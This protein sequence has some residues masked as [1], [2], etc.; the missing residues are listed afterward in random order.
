ML[1]TLNEECLHNEIMTQTETRPIVIEFH[2]S[3][4]G[5]SR[6]LTS[7]IEQLSN[8]LTDRVLFYEADIDKGK[9]L[10]EKFEICSVPTLILI[11]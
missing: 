9:K 7:I 2:A 10:A 1:K 8:D 4:C 3:W 5:K 11:K 6:M